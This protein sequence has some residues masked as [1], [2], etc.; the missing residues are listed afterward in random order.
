MS[1]TDQYTK[2][3]QVIVRETPELYKKI[4]KPYISAIPASRTQW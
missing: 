2:Q 3:E 1:N 4:V